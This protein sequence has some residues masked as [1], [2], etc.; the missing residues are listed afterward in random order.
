MKNIKDCFCCKRACIS[1]HGFM[2]IEVDCNSKNI[3]HKINFEKDGR[4]CA[5]YCKGYQD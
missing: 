4:Y 1:K 3:G 5:E 2:D